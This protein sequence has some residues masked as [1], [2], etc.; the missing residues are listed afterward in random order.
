MKIYSVFGLNILDSTCNIY[1]HQIQVVSN[2]RWLWFVKDIVFW[3]YEQ[4]LIVQ[5]L[6]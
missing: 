4:L 6:R 3:F 5:Y 1:V 2:I